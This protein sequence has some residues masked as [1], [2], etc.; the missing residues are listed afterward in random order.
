MN[1]D[2]VIRL[3][4]DAG[5]TGIYSQWVSP[6]EREHLTV[7]VTIEQIE[8]FAKIVAAAERAK[9]VEWM[10]EQ[11]YATGHGDTTEDLL[12]ELKW[13]AAEQEIRARG[14]R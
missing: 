6:T 3:A 13:Q 2:D 5:W 1:R 7:P 11:G 10:A 14:E 8:R 4:R 12:K 9:V